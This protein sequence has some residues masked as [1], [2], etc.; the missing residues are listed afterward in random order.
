MWSRINPKLKSLAEEDYSKRDTDL[1]GPGFLEKASKRLE[2][3]KTLEK[4]S[5]PQGNRPNKKFRSYAN[6]KGDLRSF[7]GEGRFHEV[8][9]WEISTPE[10]VPSLQSPST[11]KILS[12]KPESRSG[13]T[14][15]D[16]AK[17]AMIAET[18]PHIHDAIYLHNLG[19]TL[20]QVPNLGDLAP[21]GRL[22]HCLGL[23]SRAT[24]G[25]YRSC[26]GTTSS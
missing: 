23:G 16:Q 11:K 13:Q 9:Q 7:F 24:H 6:N 4:V 14:G 10:A 8:W 3:D 20:H 26:R 25:S 22:G 18:S 12:E 1:F 21:A 2:V 19:L 15:E 17:P 5:G